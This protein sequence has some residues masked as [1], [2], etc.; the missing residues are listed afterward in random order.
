M[1]FATLLGV[2]SFLSPLIS[3]IPTTFI[4][5]DAG[6]DTIAARSRSFLL[7]L[8][9]KKVDTRKKSD[10]MFL[11]FLLA[12]RFYTNAL[13]ASQGVGDR[14]TAAI[15][16]LNQNVNINTTCSFDLSTLIIT[17]QTDATHA[18]GSTTYL[19]LI[20]AMGGTALLNN[21]TLQL[22]S[23][24]R[25]IIAS[26]VQEAQNTLQVTGDVSSHGADLSKLP[27][28]TL[29]DYN[30]ILGKTFP[31][32]LDSLGVHNLP[33]NLAI[34]FESPFT[35]PQNTGID[36]VNHGSESLCFTDPNATPFCQTISP[37]PTKPPLIVP[38]E[39]CTI[40]DNLGVNLFYV[41]ANDVA[42]SSDP[43]VRASQADQI[44]RGPDIFVILD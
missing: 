36:L 22:S 27:S 3:G 35:A 6:D 42:L 40:G 21:D 31:N 29:R 10:L 19:E 15:I 23:D 16:G 1:R 25:N 43:N 38:L 41:T 17:N 7:L 8:V 4:R 30:S 11:N 14:E 20:K 33:A 32:C 26:I 13:E 12:D 34:L 28:M 44:C 2:L 9:E 24:D 5:R 39:N 37:D 18:V